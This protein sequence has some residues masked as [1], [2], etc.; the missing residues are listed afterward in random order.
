[1]CALFDF[2]SIAGVGGLAQGRQALRRF[3]E[4]TGHDPSDS[5]RFAR[6]QQPAQLEERGDVDRVAHIR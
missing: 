5:V 1:M 2:V 3:G 6:R 4:E